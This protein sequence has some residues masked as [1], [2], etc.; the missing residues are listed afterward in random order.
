M[1]G[2]FSLEF[3]AYFSI[4][5]IVLAIMFTA[6]VERQSQVFDYRDSTSLEAVASKAAFEVETAHNYG[7]GYQK[8]VELPEDV[9]GNQYDLLIEDERVIIQSGEDEL[10]APARY[11]GRTFQINSENGPFEVVNNGSVHVTPK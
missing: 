10:T 5:I 4:S 7:E 11:S 2:Q 6:T 8:T 1:K 3:F 9:N